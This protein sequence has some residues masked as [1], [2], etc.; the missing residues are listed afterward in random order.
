M[1]Y[2]IL[3]GEFAGMTPDDIRVW[4]EQDRSRQEI[5]DVFVAVSTHAYVIE[6][7]IYDFKEGTK[8]HQWASWVISKWF[9]L[10]RELTA[11]VISL[12]RDE[13]HDV[14]DKGHHYPLIPFME[15]YGYRESGGWWRKK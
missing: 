1:E 7:E 9:D 6:D 13:G 3:S 12:A 15:S 5:V 14:P 2:F 8:E 11:R 4:L 10:C